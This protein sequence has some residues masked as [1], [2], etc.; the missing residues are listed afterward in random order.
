ML[1]IQAVSANEAWRKTLKAIIERGEATGNAKYVRDEVAVIEITRPEVAP[2]DERFPMAQ[3]SLD[4]INRYIYSGQG[5]GGVAHEWTKLYYHRAFDEPHSQVEFLISKLD[6]DQPSGKALISMW[7]KSVDQE[8]EI[9]PCTLVV[10]VRIKQGALELHVHAH[11]SDAYKKLLMN[12]LEFIS[13]QHYIAGRAG[14]SVGRYYHMLDSCHIY[15][16]DAE[17]AQ[18]VAAEL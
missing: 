18:A 16:R 1:I 14:V 12:M 2:T 8:A 17:A 5:E 7:D 15:G 11:S 3:G 10:W 6:A 4:V 13:L 9:S